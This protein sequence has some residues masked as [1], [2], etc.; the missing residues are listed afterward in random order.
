VAFKCKLSYINL[1]IN[2]GE[3]MIMQKN[4]IKT[5]EVEA[6]IGGERQFVTIQADS[7]THACKLVCDRYGILNKNV[8]ECVLL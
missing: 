1:K 7:D 5:Y 6:V 4:K 8:T 2:L 3:I